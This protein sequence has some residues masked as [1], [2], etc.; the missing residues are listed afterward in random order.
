MRKSMNNT[1][2]NH[3]SYDILDLTKFILSFFV[4][5]IHAEIFPGVLYPW[6][7]VAV[8]LFFMISSFL[9][10]TRM[11]DTSESEQRMRIQKF[12]KRNLSLYFTWFI[13]LI[14]FTIYVRKAWFADGAMTGILRCIRGLLFGSTFRASWYIMASVIAVPLIWYLSK[15]INQYVLAA[16]S[17]VLYILCCMTSNYAGLL[18]TLGLGMLN[19]ISSILFG[20]IATSFLSALIW[21]VT[22]KAFADKKDLRNW[23]FSAILCI[24]SLALLFIEKKVIDILQC[25]TANDCYLMLIPT[26]CFLFSLLLQLKN[27]HIANA[28]TLRNCSTLIYVTHCEVLMC[29]SFGIKYL[30]YT[31]KFIIF[32]ISVGL[33]II[34]SMLAVKISRHQK[35]QWLTHL[36]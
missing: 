19:S 20:G 31:N 3:F 17:A 16:L 21:V 32:T 22:G 28:K 9:L 29:V 6:L 23:K 2:T 5:A 1:Q 30:G 8:P 25:S 26:C 36:W 4:V 11:N 10:F 14:P 18:D 34:G 15:K 12:I 33:L 24:I 35:F 13:I 27:I 7:R